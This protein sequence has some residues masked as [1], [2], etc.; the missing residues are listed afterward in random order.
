MSTTPKGM[1]HGPRRR[2]RAIGLALFGLSGVAC[3]AT[4]APAPRTPVRDAISWV[5]PRCAGVQSCVLGRVTAS[6]TARP[7][8]RAAI[9]LEQQLE[10][11]DGEVEPVR[12][13]ALTDEDGVFTVQDPPPGHY[14]IAIYKEARHAEVRGIVLG[15][16]GTTLV[17][18][19][20][21]P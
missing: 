15:G 12:L 3:V 8:V 9:F 17:P 14:R 18:V 20:L 6:E 11:G 7:L 21:A 16:Q 19:S 4:S 2:V 10:G 5:G 1:G 13:S